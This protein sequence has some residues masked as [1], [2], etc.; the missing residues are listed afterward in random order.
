MIVKINL[1]GGIPAGEVFSYKESSRNAV[2][3]RVI[4]GKIFERTCTS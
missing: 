1:F 4:M 2:S 3:Y